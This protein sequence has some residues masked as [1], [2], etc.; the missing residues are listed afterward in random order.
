MPETLAVKLYTGVAETVAVYRGVEALADEAGTLD[1]GAGTEDEL[2][3]PQR[4][5][6]LAILETTHDEASSVYSSK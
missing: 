6:V 3:A 5:A 4:G 2:E 1:E